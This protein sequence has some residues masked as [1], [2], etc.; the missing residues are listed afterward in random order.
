MPDADHYGPRLLPFPSLGYNRGS[1]C[2][3][4][5]PL[6]FTEFRSYSLRTAPSPTGDLAVASSADRNLL[7]GVALQIDSDCEEI[8]LGVGGGSGSPS[9]GLAGGALGCDGLSDRRLPS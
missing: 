5:E 9:L 6:P 2:L 8:Q 1:S 4:T 3:T 7:F